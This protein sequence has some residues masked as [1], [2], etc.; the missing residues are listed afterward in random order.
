MEGQRAVLVDPYTGTIIGPP[1]GGM[2]SFFR[3][4][5]SWH[6]WLAMEGE[7]R[8][9]GK[10]VTGAANLAF[11]FIVVS[12]MYIWVPRLWTRIQ[13]RNVLWFR[14]GVQGRARDF[15]WHNVIG[16]WS[17]VPLALIVLG[18]VPISY[19]WASN[20]VYRLV[21][22]E[23]PAPA[24]PRPA[25]PEASA[26]GPNGGQGRQTDRGTPRP[27][28]DV[29]GLDGAYAA[30]LREVP[31]WRSLAIRIPAATQRSVTLTIDEGYGGQPQKR[32]T[33]TVT[34][35]GEVEGWEAFRDL[36]VGR[37][38]RSWF[39]FVHTGEYY[40]LPGQ[41]VAGLVSAGAVVLVWT[42]LALATRRFVNWLSSRSRQRGSE[43]SRKAA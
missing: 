36:S 8:A 3:L 19:P 33:L 7:G 22:E 16:I 12:G 41:T 18:A 34:R 31:G 6:R 32:G 5:T 11:L 17:A 2:R 23:P 40:G 13:F 1:P 9:T 10:A 29:S 38:L 28:P 35:A 30:A 26:R 14:Q 4:V 20:L 24:Q 15:N 43:P 21:G 42:G 37:R 25:G 27:A 39:R